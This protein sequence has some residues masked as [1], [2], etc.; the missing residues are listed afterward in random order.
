MPVYKWIGCSLIKIL[1]GEAAAVI[2][3]RGKGARERK[4]VNIKTQ[5][6]WFQNPI[7]DKPSCVQWS[8]LFINSSFASVI[9]TDSLVSD[10]LCLLPSRC[11][12]LFLYLA[13]LTDLL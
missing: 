4:R 2:G 1:N 3:E 8:S 12:S 5:R 13:C 6:E 9:V 11:V 7:K 10:W